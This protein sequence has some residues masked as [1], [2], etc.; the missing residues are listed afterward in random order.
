M[1]KKTIEFPVLLI[2]GDCALCNQFTMLILRFETR[3]IITFGSIQSP[4]GQQLLKD[5]FVD[6][7]LI[8]SVILIEHSGISVKSEAVFRVLRFMGGVAKIGLVFS[9]FPRRW[10]DWAYDLIAKYRRQWFGRQD[11]CRLNSGVDPKR[12]IEN[13]PTQDQ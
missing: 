12:F 5:H 8:D 4:D 3:P 1:T 10:T 13:R 7:V 6:Q 11:Y 9:L 2:D